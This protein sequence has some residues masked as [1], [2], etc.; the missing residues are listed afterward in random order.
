MTVTEYMKKVAEA[1]SEYCKQNGYCVGCVFAA[2]GP[3][4]IGCLLSGTP[5]NWNFDN[6]SESEGNKG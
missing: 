4:K 6:T 3:D 5:N 2:E 1:I